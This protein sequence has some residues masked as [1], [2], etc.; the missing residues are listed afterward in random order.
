MWYSFLGDGMSLATVTAA[1]IYEGQQ[2]GQSGEAH[3]L[4]FEQF[5]YVGLAKVFMIH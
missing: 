5:P 2:R 3:S 1:R 4:S